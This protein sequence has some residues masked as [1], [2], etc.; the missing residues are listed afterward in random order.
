[1]YNEQRKLT[2]VMF[3]YL[4][5]ESSFKSILCTRAEGS[6]HH[7]PFPGH[8]HVEQGLE[9]GPSLQLSLGGLCSPQVHKL[10]SL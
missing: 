5:M 8:R 6:H 9:A 1:M 3:T 4:L 10:C 2:F 7:L